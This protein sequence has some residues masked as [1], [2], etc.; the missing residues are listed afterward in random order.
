[1]IYGKSVGSKGKLFIFEPYSFSYKI[2]VKNV[3]LNKLSKITTVYN[4]GVSNK[5][6][7]GYIFVSWR[8]TGGSQIILDDRIDRLQGFN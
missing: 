6:Q 8:N 2:V 3:Y 5:R 1:M 7:S 4:K